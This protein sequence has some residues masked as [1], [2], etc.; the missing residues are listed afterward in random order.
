MWR[1]GE[2]KPATELPR[3][4]LDGI[5]FELMARTPPM[6]WEWKTMLRFLMFK[7]GD[8]TGDDKSFILPIG[9]SYLDE[10]P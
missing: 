5:D 2:K 9:N 1:N 4:G 7:K 6:R 3:S 10:T 8:E